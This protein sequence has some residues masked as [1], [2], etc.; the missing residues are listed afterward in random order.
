MAITMG[1]LQGYLASRPHTT[2]HVLIKKKDLLQMIN[3]IIAIEC[4]DKNDYCVFCKPDTTT[5][6]NLKLIFDDNHFNHCPHCGRYL[7]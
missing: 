4:P 3:N 1:D 5:Y 6:E 7:K 2:E